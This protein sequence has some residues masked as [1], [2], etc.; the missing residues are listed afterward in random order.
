VVVEL[1]REDRTV[2]L[3]RAYVLDS[4]T[5]MTKVTVPEEIRGEFSASADWPA[6][7]YNGEIEILLGIEELALQLKRLEIRGNLGIFK[8]HLSA[9]TILGGRHKNIF[10]AQME[11]SQACMMLR[12]AAAPVAQQN[13]HIKQ[14]DNLFQQGDTMGDYIPKTCSNCKNCSTCTFAGRSI[15]QKER[16]ELEYIERGI[17]RMYLT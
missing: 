17:R 12:R 2:A 11:L 8:S 1:L 9:T 4:I 16:I 13:C 5:D 7:R 6:D 14:M 3:V 10:P 15:S